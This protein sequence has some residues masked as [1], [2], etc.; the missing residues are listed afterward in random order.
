MVSL[1][2]PKQLC[3]FFKLQCQ[4]NLKQRKT[5]SKAIFWNV[6]KKDKPSTPPAKQ[7]SKCRG[8]TTFKERS[9]AVT[10]QAPPFI[11]TLKP[12]APLGAWWKREGVN[13]LRERVAMKGVGECGAGCQGCLFGRHFNE[14]VAVLWLL[15]FNVELLELFKL[16]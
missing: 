10:L 4:S 5:I 7:P 13:I 9:R 2:F 8:F 1:N 12:S 3:F 6:F 11:S 15:C 16:G 14:G